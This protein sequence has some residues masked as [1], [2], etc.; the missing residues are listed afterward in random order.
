MEVLNPSPRW[1]RPALFP[2]PFLLPFADQS[3]LGLLVYAL[4]LRTIV[5]PGLFPTLG[6]LNI[7]RPPFDME[8][9]NITPI[10]CSSVPH[11]EGG[12]IYSMMRGAGNL[13]KWVGLLGSEIRRNRTHML[14]PCETSTQDMM[15]RSVGSWA[16][17]L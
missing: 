16:F 11:R 12:D 5:F 7:C 8:H 4:N 6:R 10:V 13:L 15:P 3:A 2:L 1:K 14:L 17:F 9:D